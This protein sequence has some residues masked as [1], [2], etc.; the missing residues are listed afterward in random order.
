MT[1]QVAIDWLYGCPSDPS[2]EEGRA[3]AAAR[4]VFD[5]AGV[6][7]P[8]AEADY[9]AQ[10]GLFADQAGITGLALTWIK[11]RDAAN[12]A[13]TE[14]WPDPSRANVSIECKHV[15]PSANG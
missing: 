5:R 11:A 8:A 10:G 12:I 14:D 9:W 1:Y 15:A 4:A 6:D 13:A 7:G 3:R 2:R